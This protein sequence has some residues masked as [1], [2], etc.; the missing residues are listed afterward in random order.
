MNQDDLEKMNLK[1]QEW[2]E[3]RARNKA[4]VSQVGFQGWAKN[5]TFASY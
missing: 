2:N 3:G 5:N 4:H 1:E